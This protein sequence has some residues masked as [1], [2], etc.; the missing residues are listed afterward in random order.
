MSEE[1]LISGSCMECG[2]SIEGKIMSS[3]EISHLA[4]KDQAMFTKNIHS[5]LCASCGAELC[6]DCY[7][8][9]RSFWSLKRETGKCNRCGKAF[10]IGKVRIYNL[11]QSDAKPIPTFP[12]PIPQS[13]PDVIQKLTDHNHPSIRSDILK[14][15]LASP[16]RQDLEIIQ[17]AID[18]LTF[19]KN[20]LFAKKPNPISPQAAESAILRTLQANNLKVD[21]Y[22]IQAYLPYLVS[23]PVLEYELDQLDS[24]T[25]CLYRLVE[26]HYLIIEKLENHPKP[27]PEAGPVPVIRPS[28]AIQPE[29]KPIITP[30]QHLLN[31]LS[32]IEE[33]VRLPAINQVMSNPSQAGLELVEEALFRLTGKA[34]IDFYHPRFGRVIAGD[35]QEAVDKIIALAQGG[36]FY[37]KPEEVQALIPKVGILNEELMIS[38]YKLDQKLMA[39]YQLLGIHMQIALVINPE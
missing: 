24:K 35:P 3:S 23:S 34:N 28:L 2:K 32:S 39:I 14:T 26:T 38:L 18:Q 30:N 6:N 10:I 1:S 4:L 12:T 7:K 25:L 8:K 16:T 21:P 9:R 27:Q 31:A 22:S 37:T 20:K 5:R 36:Q 19:K 29:A 11:P 17:K 15:M 13:I 33:E